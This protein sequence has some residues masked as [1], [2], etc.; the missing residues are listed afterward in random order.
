MCLLKV[1]LRSEITSFNGPPLLEVVLTDKPS[2]SWIKDKVMSFTHLQ[3][4]KRFWL[5]K[6]QVRV[7]HTN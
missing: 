4:H 3:E 7:L 2:G 5:L 6:C 1:L